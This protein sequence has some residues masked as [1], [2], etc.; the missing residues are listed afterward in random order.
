MPRVA[1]T[2]GSPNLQT[3]TP[4]VKRGRSGARSVARVGNPMFGAPPADILAAH[5]RVAASPFGSGRLSSAAPPIEAS[6]GTVR[7]TAGSA[8]LTQRSKSVLRRVVKA[9]G[10]RGGTLRVEG[11]ASSRTR[12]MDLV[13]HHMVN[14]DV[15]RRRVNAV[16]KELVRLGVPSQSVDAIALSDSRPIYDEI[17]PSREAGNQRVEIYFVK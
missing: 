7:F 13:K 14:F 4:L 5:G 11:H 9:F 8:A 6:A 10:K 16:A 15:S 1:K 12:D 2:Q 17:M 3:V